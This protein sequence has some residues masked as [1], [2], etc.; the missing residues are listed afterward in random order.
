MEAE[1]FEENLIEN[2]KKQRCLYDKRDGFYF[3]RN[4]K[5]RAWK[6]VAENILL[7]FSIEMHTV[8]VF[9]TSTHILHKKKNRCSFG[10]NF[11]HKLIK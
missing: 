8:A 3:N 10:L 4:V 1:H 6:D 9:S 2:V 11:F 7:W 5:E